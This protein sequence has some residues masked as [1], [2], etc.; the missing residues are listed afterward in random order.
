MREEG[1]AERSPRTEL[2]ALGRAR[3]GSADSAVEEVKEEE[4]E[5]EA[6]DR[7]ASFNDR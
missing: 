3:T 1:T 5:E 6:L 7:G 2:F 4:E